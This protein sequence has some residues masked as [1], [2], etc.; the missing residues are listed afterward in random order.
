MHLEVEQHHV[1]MF[2][3]KFTRFMIMFTSSVSGMHPIIFWG[4][5]T[6]ELFRL[7]IAVFTF[8]ETKCTAQITLIICLKRN[9]HTGDLDAQF[10]KER[11]CNGR[12]QNYHKVKYY[13]I[14]KALS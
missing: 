2:F 14:K 12:G 10:M 6:A 13:K 9:N 7:Q 5:F 1:T 8:T 4:I 11:I 3:Q